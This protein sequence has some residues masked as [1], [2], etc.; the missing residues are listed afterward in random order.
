MAYYGWQIK[1][2]E[3][4]CWGGGAGRLL[5]QFCSTK[6]KKPNETKLAVPNV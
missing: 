5:E 4:L 2:E 1:I 6:H 3:R